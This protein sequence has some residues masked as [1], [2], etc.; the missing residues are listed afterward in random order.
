[1]A[2][3]KFY[4]NGLLLNKKY[5]YLFA[6]GSTIKPAVGDAIY[7]S[8]IVGHFLAEQN[9]VELSFECKN[10]EFRFA[11]QKIALRDIDLR[12]RARQ[13]NSDNGC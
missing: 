2:L 4:L 5:I 9:N 3:P 6:Y 10:L 13:V 11:S 1:M 7:Y 8:D 12:R